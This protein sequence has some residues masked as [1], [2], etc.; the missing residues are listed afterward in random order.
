[1]H[2]LCHYENT[3]HITLLIE[4]Y[5]AMCCALCNTWLEENCQDETC[6]FCQRRPMTP[7]TQE[8]HEKVLELIQQYAKK[9]LIPPEE[10]DI[11][12]WDDLYDK[13]YKKVS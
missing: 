2:P 9:G 6:E 13:M 10:K 5:D 4:E 1:M 3:H 7:F 8:Q 11:P 12:A